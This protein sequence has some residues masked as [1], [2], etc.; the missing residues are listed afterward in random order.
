MLFKNLTTLDNNSTVE[1]KIQWL[2]TNQHYCAKPFHTLQLSVN[3]M[4]QYRASPCCNYTGE[5]GL[6]PPD[7]QF[8]Q[9]KTDIINGV[10][11]KGCALC[12]QSEETNDYS[13]RIR[14]MLYWQPQEI[15]NFINTGVIKEFN[16]GTMFS[17]VC[18][19]ACRSC[20]PS[21]S[22]TYSL[23][24]EQPVSKSLSI[25]I[26]ENVDK[27]EA[28]LTYTRELVEKYELVRIGL[29]GGETMLQRGATEY[30]NFLASL[31]NVNNIVLALTSNFT[32]LNQVVF[33]HLDK[34]RRLDLT[35]SVDSCGENYHYVRW[36]AQFSKIQNNIDE[37]LRIR[38]ESKALTTFGIAS[39]FGLNN[40][41][42]IK[43]YLD[44]LYNSFRKRSDITIHVLLLTQPNVISIENLPIRYRPML[45]EYI[46]QAIA[47]PVLRNPNALP[48]KIFLEGV[49]TFLKS[50]RVVYSR[51]T[52]FLKFTANFDRR[53][54]C[55]FDHFNK[56]LYDI[57]TIEDKTLYQGFLK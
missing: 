16:L 46:R 9:L 52:D 29:I 7:D 36:P 34:F 1:Q 39:V 15:N 30:I 5:I 43:E 4:D 28:L 11:N 26:R 47:H 57:L 2:K 50:D 21:A 41:F 55:Y 3:E 17:N 18:N 44:F 37:Y 51:F 13:E 35:A 6:L 42:Y 14:D 53:T 23:I 22:S 38:K 10:K 56:R 24:T 40:I 27:W 54:D 8:L 12:W 25:D 19:L 45:S 31:K 20:T 33:D 49:E 48:M 32:S